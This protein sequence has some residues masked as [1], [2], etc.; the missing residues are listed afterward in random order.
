MREH[1]RS[2][3]RVEQA[4]AEA[5]VQTKVVEL[6]KSTRTAELAAQALDVE[7][8]SIVKSLLFLADEKP[9]LALVAGDKRASTA[10]IAAAMGA[11]TA[12]IASADEVRAI[13]GYAIG[14]VPP[15]GYDEPFPVLIDR[16]L[17]RFSRVYAAA[18]T[19]RAVFPISFEELL[20]ATRGRLAD[21]SE[22]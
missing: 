11:S 9:L 5:G 15:I 7:L 13:T 20:R 22:T 6:D 1:S 14:G 4:L 2:V 10:S 17:S 21:I 18:G 3:T 8:G 12:R 16:S 19:P